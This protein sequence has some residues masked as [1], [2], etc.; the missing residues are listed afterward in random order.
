MAL[1]DKVVECTSIQFS[2]FL[3]FHHFFL[4]HQDREVTVVKNAPG[5]SGKGYERERNYI[6]CNPSI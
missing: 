1:L 5:Q 6:T 4:L 3:E 2:F